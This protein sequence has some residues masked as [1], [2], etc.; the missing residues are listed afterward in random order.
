MNENIPTQAL[1][2]ELSM[3]IH[4]DKDGSFK[5]ELLQ[6]FQQKK[7]NLRA[8]LD[9]GTL[10]PNEYE[11]GKKLFASLDAATSILSNIK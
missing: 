1:L 11:V 8:L 10:V 3:K 2:N 4:E 5:K 9:G 7:Q 6:K